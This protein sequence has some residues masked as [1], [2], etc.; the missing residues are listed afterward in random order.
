MAAHVINVP[1]GHPGDSLGAHKSAMPLI[2]PSNWRPGTRIDGCTRWGTS[3]HAPATQENAAALRQLARF[4]VDRVFL[5]DDFRIAES[6]GTIG[7]CFCTEHLEEFRQ[8]H[9]YGPAMK[10]EL[11]ES[12]KGRRLTSIVPE[13]G[14][15]NACRSAPGPCSKGAKGTFCSFGLS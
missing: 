15:F 9:G 8:L 7:G 12:I 2:P 4:G 14:A 10:D 6:P 1:L 11:V 5:D 3:L 13:S